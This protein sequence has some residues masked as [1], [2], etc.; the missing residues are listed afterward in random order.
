MSPVCTGEDPL[1]DARGWVRFVILSGSPFRGKMIRHP[2]HVRPGR[3]Q[4]APVRHVYMIGNIGVRNCEIVV[5]SDAGR[6][7]FRH[8]RG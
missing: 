6:F 5:T 3:K 1:A 7:A 2:E 8:R 4:L